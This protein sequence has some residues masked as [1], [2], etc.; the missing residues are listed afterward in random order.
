M[1]LSRQDT[2]QSIHPRKPNL[3]S[4]ATAEIPGDLPESRDI[5]ILRDYS[6]AAGNEEESQFA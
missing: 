5:Q 2:G 6:P 3:L 1:S 4:P